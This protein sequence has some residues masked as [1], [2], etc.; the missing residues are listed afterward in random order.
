MVEGRG[1][2]IL[3][4][5]GLAGAAAAS[6]PLRRLSREWVTL[7]VRLVFVEVVS[8]V[9]IAGRF[10]LAGKAL[11][12]DPTLGQATALGLSVIIAAAVGI[13]PAGVGIREG[14]AALLAPLVGIEPAVAVTL[15]LVDRLVA[16]V[17]MAVAT[18]LIGRKSSG[19]STEGQDE[20]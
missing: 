5:L 9:L 6:M 13:V 8:V 4:P 18:P 17:T 12:L 15:V 1:T 11:G 3:V 20:A 10:L 19:R 7:G 2:V 16:L 14:S